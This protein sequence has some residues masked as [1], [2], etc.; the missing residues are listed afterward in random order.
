MHATRFPAFVLALHHHNMVDKSYDITMELEE[1]T[2]RE[3]AILVQ[4]RLSFV[5]PQQ[6]I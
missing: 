6:D 5:Q 4:E 3:L 1:W 2:P